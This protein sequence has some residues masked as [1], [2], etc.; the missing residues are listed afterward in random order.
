MK[1]NAIIMILT[2]FLLGMIIFQ[3]EARRGFYGYDYY[4]NEN[5]NVTVTEVEKG[6]QLMVTSDDPKMIQSIKK[7]ANTYR[8]HLFAGGY[9]CDDYQGRLDASWGAGLFFKR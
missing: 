7:E 5:I 2:L 6:I 8:R 9:H 4:T 1:Q 3:A